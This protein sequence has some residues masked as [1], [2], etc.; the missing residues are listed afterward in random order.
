MFG[1]PTKGYRLG[2]KQVLKYRNAKTAKS[3]PLKLHVAIGLHM[4]VSV[5][6]KNEREQ[7]MWPV[8]AETKREI[9]Q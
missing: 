6:V 5:R 4:V 1:E 7:G 3:I 9:Q 8:E 2:D